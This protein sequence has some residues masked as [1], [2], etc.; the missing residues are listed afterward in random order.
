MSTPRLCLIAACARGGVIGINNRL[1][2]HLPED[3]KFFRETTRGKPVIM[4]RKTWESLPEA[5]RPLPGRLNIVVSRN[6]AYAAPGATVV[7]SL[8]AALAAASEASEAFLIGGAELYRQGMALADALLL[9]EIN[10][11]FEGDAFFPPVDPQHWQEAGRD[12]QVAASGL[13]FAFVR[14]TRR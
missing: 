10:Q 8:D 7:N 2:W 3:M 4:G 5:F 11:D 6:A 9:T 14:Y 13:P 1:P 12:A